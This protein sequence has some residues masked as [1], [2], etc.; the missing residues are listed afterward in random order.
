[1]LS[2]LFN[3]LRLEKTQAHTH[4]CTHVRTHT[5]GK[6]AWK[7][8]VTHNK[9]NICFLKTTHT[10]LPKPNAN[11]YVHAHTSWYVHACFILEMT[12]SV[13]TT[14]L[15]SKH[16]LNH[17]IYTDVAICMCL[18]TPGLPSSVW[19]FLLALPC[20]CPGVGT[21]LRSAH[22]YSCPVEG[23]V[24][25]PVSDDTLDTPYFYGNV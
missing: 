6:W 11:W 15:N 22:R 4:T 23:N 18:L 21:T 8:A 7:M 10:A 2:C 19:S 3:I 25:T 1:M 5:A 20:Q 16:Q 9:A 12:K 24:L 14:N 13:Q 17:Y